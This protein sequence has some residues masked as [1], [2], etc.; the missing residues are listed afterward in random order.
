MGNKVIIVGIDNIKIDEKN[1]Q[2]KKA[3]GS[4]SETVP[5]KSI[6]KKSI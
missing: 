4:I 3:N 6:N 2:T 1:V 5:P